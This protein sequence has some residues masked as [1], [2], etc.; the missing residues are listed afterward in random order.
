MKFTYK[1][2]TKNRPERKR[3]NWGADEVEANDLLHHQ[4]LIVTSM[5]G[6]NSS[7]NF[8]LSFTKRIPF[9]EKI[10][11]TRQLSIMIKAGL[12]SSKLL[13]LSKNNPKTSI[14]KKSLPKSLKMSKAVPLSRLL[15]PN[16]RILS[17]RFIPML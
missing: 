3:F 15:L 2:I 14:L 12:R 17:A 7:A 8:L 4:G 6:E 11:F 1:S 5:K 13:K 9:K 16:I 10:I